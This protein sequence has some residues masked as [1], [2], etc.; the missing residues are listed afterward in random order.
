MLLSNPLNS[1][2]MNEMKLTLGEKFQFLRQN[3]KKTEKEIA[4]EL[5]L[6]LTTYKKIEEDFLYPTDSL[7]R[8]AAKLY[9][10]TYEELLA[11]GEEE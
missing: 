8:K 3:T 1:I 4:K 6:A 2:Q 7:I 10:M 5:K 11:V 9:G